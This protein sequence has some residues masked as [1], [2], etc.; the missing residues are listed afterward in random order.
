MTDAQKTELW[1]IAWNL[2]HGESKAALAGVHG[3]LGYKPTPTPTRETFD[4]R[5]ERN[6]ATLLGGKVEAE[7]RKL[8]TSAVQVANRFGCKAKM[9]SGTRTYAQQNALYE[10]G[11]TKPGPKVTNARGG[12]SN[13]NF[14]I[15]ADLGIFKGSRYAGNSDPALS[16]AVHRAIAAEVKREGLNLEWGGDWRSFQDLP[17]WGYRTG[18]TT[19]QMRERVANG[20]PII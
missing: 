1:T 4:E 16:E 19:A 9:I 5:T 2:Q 15:A 6:L 7:F 8:M 3:L 17:H 12:Y 13:H 11:R 14:G 18:L 10:K 20:Q